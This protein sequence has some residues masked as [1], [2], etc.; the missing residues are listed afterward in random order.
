MSGIC[1][2]PT[3][4]GM[5]CLSPS[6]SLCLSSLFRKTYLLYLSSFFCISGICRRLHH[7]GCLLYSSSP[8]SSL[9]FHLFFGC[10]C[11][12]QDMYSRAALLCKQPAFIAFL[13]RGSASSFSLTSHLCSFL[14]PTGEEEAS[15]LRQ[16]EILAQQRFDALCV[17]MPYACVLSAGCVYQRGTVMAAAHISWPGQV[18]RAP[19][20]QVQAQGI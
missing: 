6:S 14:S 7:Q 20:I 18:N 3:P 9:S 17:L 15:L 1:R 10:S 19:V 13:H 12:L 4:Q 8:C 5:P 2:W 16:R 11:S